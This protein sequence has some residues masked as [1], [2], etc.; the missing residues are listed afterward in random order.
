MPTRRLIV[1]V[2]VVLP[3]IAVARPASADITVF[4]G[5]VPT[6]SHRLVTGAAVGISLLVVG[7]EFEYAGAGESGDGTAPA[8]RTGLVNGLI[9]TPA[10]F[11]RV[12]L[13][14][15][16]GVGLYRETL[17]NESETS[18]AVGLGGGVKISL[19]GPLRLR[20]D[21]RVLQLRGEP[22][23]DRVHRVYA[24]LNLKF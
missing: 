15:T 5:S 24:G 18:V 7:V 20:L 22:L 12:Q 16:A 4:L 10:S 17:V 8:L 11:G 1:A 9:Q 23:H 21:Y 19:A 2:V 3:L 14:A 13:Y 6:P